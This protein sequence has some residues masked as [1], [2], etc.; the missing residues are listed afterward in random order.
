MTDIPSVEFLE[1][2]GFILKPYPDGNYWLLMKHNE[3]FIQLDESRTQ[4]TLYNEGWVEDRLTQ[5]ELINTI[6]QFK[7][8]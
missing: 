2:N 5:V 4:I 1:A 8:Q 3:V 6:Q 7:A